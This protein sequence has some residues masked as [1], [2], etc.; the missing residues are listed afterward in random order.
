MIFPPRIAASVLA[1]IILAACSGPSAP[2]EISPVPSPTSIPTIVAVATA[3]LPPGPTPSP[4]PAPTATPAPSPT[5]TQTPV[6]SP[7]PSPA[8]QPPP[9]PVPA[10]PAITV[11]QADTV[12]KIVAL[13]FDATSD[14]G[15]AAQILDLLK[16]QRIKASF[17]L[18]GRWAE[19]NPDLVKRMVAEGHQI[20]N[21]TYD[22]AS[23]TGFSTGKPALTTQQRVDE[24]SRMRD[25]VL[26]ETGYDVKPYFR[27][28]Y[29]DVDGSVLQDIAN[30]GYSVN[31]MWS[32]DSLGW[33]GLKA[34]DIVKRTI[35]G[36]TPGAIVVM[37]VS[38]HSDDAAALPRVIQ[39]LRDAGYQFV[40]VKQMVGR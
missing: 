14:T 18:T 35:K 9:T 32:I 6:P 33:S 29:G 20:M 36:I 40:T 11:S 26:A 31:V 27:P 21:D 2:D 19:Q 39:Q 30:A 7:T 38:S 25:V 15:H 16:Q 10:A 1:L 12:Q 28:P 23:F 34:D 17:G 8:A 37:D 13:T 22:H 4:T 5:P 3:T 24:L